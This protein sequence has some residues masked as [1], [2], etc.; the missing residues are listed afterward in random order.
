MCVVDIDTGP[1]LRL[2]LSVG[3][4]THYQPLT[5]QAT[6]SLHPFFHFPTTTK[7]D[8]LPAAGIQICPGGRNL[9]FSGR[10]FGFAA[11]SWGRLI[12]QQSVRRKP[13]GAAERGGEREKSAR[14]MMSRDDF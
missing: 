14:L 12:R 6:P 8:F 2:P 4:A 9:D 13:R 10:N 11:T 7:S 5:G 1:A 3:P